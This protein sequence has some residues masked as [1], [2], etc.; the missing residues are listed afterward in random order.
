MATGRGPG[1]VAH[2][3]GGDMMPHA[4]PG[5]MLG[6]RRLLASSGPRSACLPGRYSRPAPG[7]R[8]TRGGPVGAGIGRVG[9]VFR[10]IPSLCE[11]LGWAS[12]PDA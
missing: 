1:L 10:P 12:G 5:L 11:G 2:T 8:Q 6:P 4:L 7:P 9:H 3:K